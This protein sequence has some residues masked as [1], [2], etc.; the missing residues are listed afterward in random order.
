MNYTQILEELIQA[1]KLRCIRCD[2][3]RKD[4]C[5]LNLND[6]LQGNFHCLEIEKVVSNALRIKENLSPS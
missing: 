1:I 4:T 6:P 2:K 5:D 3:P